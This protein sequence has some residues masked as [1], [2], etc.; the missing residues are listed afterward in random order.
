ME[1]FNKQHNIIKYLICIFFVFILF[2]STRVFLIKENELD[3]KFAPLYENK[4]ILVENKNY[5]IN[6][7]YPEFKNK[8]INK[9]I[10][11]WLN[12]Y[13]KKFEKESNANKS[14]LNIEYSIYFIEDYANIFFSIDNSL[15]TKDISENFIIDFGT[16]KFINITKIY[17]KNY[18]LDN[19]KNVSN[20]YSTYISNSILDK[21]IN[22]F[23]YFINDS[24]I[25]IYFSDLKLDNSIS[26]IPNIKIVKD[27][28][29]EQGHIIDKSKKMVALTF[30]DGPSKYSLD[31]LECL[32]LNDSKATFFEIGRNM[33][34]HKD[35]TK[36]LYDN[37]MEIGNHTFSHTSL[38]KISA[39]DVAEEINLTSKIYNQ[40]TGKDLSL[41]RPPYGSVNKGV[42]NAIS[43]PIILWDI[44]TRDWDYKNPEISA[45]IILDNVSDGDIILMHDVYGET[46]ELAKI[47]IPE[48]KARGY[49][50][51]TVSELAKYKDHELK[52]GQITRKINQKSIQNKN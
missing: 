25:T 12:S 16:N 29:L 51:V 32:N 50:L 34:N 44:D 28:E 40:I 9:K 10:N 7:K 35:I 27:N 49:E 52:N 3:Y 23:D 47:I 14:S 2:S 18:I 20:K 33:N 24:S 39:S 46:V 37:G 31:I 26:Y 22:K 38:P 42:K 8:T 30:D 45:P 41:V 13:I 5:T 1:W 19:I 15:N 17:N 43:F 48:L 6:V 11:L 36:K 4:D 21:D